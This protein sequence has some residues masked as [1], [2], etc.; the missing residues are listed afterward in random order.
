[1]GM[2][3]VGTPLVGKVAEIMDRYTLAINR[4]SE[5]GVEVGMIFAVIGFGGEIVDPE[6]KQSLGPRPVEKLRVKVADVYEKFCVAETYRLVTPSRSLDYLLGPNRDLLREMAKTL[7]ALPPGPERE[8][9]ADAPAP[10]EGTPTDS[11][12]H[13]EVGDTVRQVGPLA[14]LP[15]QAH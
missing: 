4:G 15:P 10:R 6:T 14:Q 7:S 11:V 1:M 5:H 12:I 8:R 3:E 2:A 9:F 13:V